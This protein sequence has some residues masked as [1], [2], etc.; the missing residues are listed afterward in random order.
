MVPGQPE[1]E[2]VPS[3]GGEF[4]L[5]QVKIIHIKFITDKAG[6]VVAVEFI[7]P[8]GIFEAKRVK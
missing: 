3:L 1:Y 5:K 2:L 4:V 7:Q 6:K 8:N